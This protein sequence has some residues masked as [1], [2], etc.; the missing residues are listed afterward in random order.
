MEALYGIFAA[1]MQFALSEYSTIR[2]QQINIENRED[3]QAFQHNEN[4]LARFATSRAGQYNDLIGLGLNPNMALASVSGS[5]SGGV[6][7]TS[8]PAAPMNDV[9][10]MLFGQIPEQ[11][12]RLMN[13]FVNRGNTLE[14]TQSKILQNYYYP[15]SHQAQMDFVYA[16][17]DELYHKGLLDD[18]EARLLREQAMWVAPLS[19][20]QVV[21][22]MSQASEAIERIHKIWSDI[23]VDESVIALNGTQALLNNALAVEAGE[24]SKYYKE[25]T[26]T[27]KELGYLYGSQQSLN[28]SVAGFYQKYGNLFEKQGELLDFDIGLRQLLDGLPISP[29]LKDN[30]VALAASDEGSKKAQKLM[31]KYLSFCSDTYDNN[32]RN[33]WRNYWQNFALGID[34]GDVLNSATQIG[35]GFINPAYG[36]AKAM[37]GGSNVAGGARAS[38]RVAK[39]SSRLTNY[40]PRTRTVN[41]QVQR[42]FLNSNGV[43]MWYN[44]YE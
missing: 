15:E 14:D 16:Q 6:G 40:T 44:V 17:C 19:Q 37:A 23:L 28:D 20:A 7:G 13:D 41:G 3:Q 26:N 42:S 21:D 36:V 43:E 1:M 2:N 4:E 38:S 5:A 8:N 34:A 39:A 24:R 29:D 18:A 33:S 22:Y 27:T 11:L 9:A 32:I 10:G 30:I 25:L 12:S 35:V 31:E